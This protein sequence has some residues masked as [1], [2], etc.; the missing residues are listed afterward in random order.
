M[1]YK[2]SKV[3]SFCNDILQLFNFLKTFSMLT[4]FLNLV[5]SMPCDLWSF[6]G[7][8]SVFLFFGVRYPWWESNLGIDFNTLT[9]RLLG[10]NC[11]TLFLSWIP[12]S[13]GYPTE[14]KVIFF[15]KS[16]KTGVK[17]EKRV[18][19]SV[20]RGCNLKMV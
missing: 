18:E 4:K 15:W 8:L 2:S 10:G 12:W 16:D 20:N 17:V 14:N 6:L 5:Y 7:T 11:N 19:T 3:R 13:L 1:S 9:P